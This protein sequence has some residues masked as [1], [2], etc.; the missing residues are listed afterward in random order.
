LWSLMDFA[1]PR[2]LG[3]H[4]TFVKQFS[5]PISKGSFGGAS[6]YQVELK[7]HLSEQLRQLITPHLLRRTKVNA[8]LMA[9]GDEGACPDVED[10]MGDGQAE[11]KKLP[12]KRETIVWLNSS[13]EQ[14]DAYKKVLQESDVIREACIQKKLGFEVFRAIGMLKRLCN[15]PSLLLPMKD[16]A[17]WG[18]YLSDATAQ[19][20]ASSAADLEDASNEAA[21]VDTLPSDSGPEQLPQADEVTKADNAEVGVESVEATLSALGRSRDDIL[22]YSSKLR[23]LNSLLPGLAKN[24]HPR[25]SSLKV[26]RC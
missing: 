14:L 26:S 19:M 12:P 25:W 6:C 17:A 16:K 20:E 2:L 18:D 11:A 4:A 9:E 23:C 8:G 10:D 5:D 15:H 21:A 7:K 13:Q 24:G 22:S 3:N 1:Q